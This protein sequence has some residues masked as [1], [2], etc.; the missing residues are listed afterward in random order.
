VVHLV[1][2]SSHGVELGAGS[3]PAHEPGERRLRAS[4]L[5]WTILRPI[6]FMSNALRWRDSIAETGTFDEP[7]GDGRQA[8]IHPADIGAVA[9]KALTTPGHEGVV[10][11]LTGPEALSSAQYA[12][13]LSAAIGRPVRH[14][15]VAE[16]VYRDRFVRYGAPPALVESL[17]RLYALVKSGDLDMVTPDV[18]AVL[19][20]PAR[21]FDEWARDNA[22]A[23]RPSP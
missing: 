9:A 20:R 7:S 16:D 23:F 6:T 13:K 21:G 19:G 4:S 8:M 12:Q 18:E 1:L 14:V 2:L 17:M 5:P 15:D 10:Y 3:G 22:N 11:E